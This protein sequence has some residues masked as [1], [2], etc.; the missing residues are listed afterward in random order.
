MKLLPL[1]FLLFT[2]LFGDK[3]L[4]IASYNVEN[5]FD[6]DKSGLEYEEYIPNTS[7]DWNQRNYKI[8][9]ENIARVIKEIDA[10][11][12]AL[13]EVESLQALIDLRFTLKQNGLY[14]QY[15]SIADKKNTTVKVALLS[16]IPF[17][18]S[19]ELSVTQTDEH[20]NI[21]ETKFKIDDKDLYL[22]INHWKSKSG[23][24]SQR[25]ISAKTL[26]KRVDEIGFDKNI[27]LLGDFNSDYE[28]HLKFARKRNLNDTDGK[29]GINHILGT[30]NQQNRASHVNFAKDSFYNLWYDA[31][32]EKRYTYIFKDEKEAMDNILVSQS[33]LNSKEI[34]YINRSITNFDKEYLF[35]KGNINRWEISHARVK[36]HKGKGYSDHLPIVA[37]F[38][39]K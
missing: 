16:K 12:I 28:E 31:E 29:T 33:L 36:K 21:L 4:T 25:I 10:D 23:P 9:L 7:S 2:T 35:K 37:K 19:K 13:Q 39:V 14:Y 17:V 6:L 1:L 32:P 27:I 5:L 8:K 15:Y 24:E 18:Y 22:F 3:T 26:M 20:R 30:I 11:I 38:S 34:S